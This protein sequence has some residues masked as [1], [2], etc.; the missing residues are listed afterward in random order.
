MFPWLSIFEA[1]R[2][3]L[4]PPSILNPIALSLV[5]TCRYVGQYIASRPN[6]LRKKQKTEKVRTVELYIR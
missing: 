5:D 4:M 1:E 3:S 2:V 6:Q